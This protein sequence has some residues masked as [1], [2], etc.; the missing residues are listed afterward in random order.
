MEAIFSEIKWEIER[1]V[2]VALRDR[3]KQGSFDFEALETMVKDVM[4]RCGTVAVERLLEHEDGSSLTRQ[5][6]CGGVF[7]VEKRNQCKRICTVVGSARLARTME[8]C[9]RCKKRRV[10]E[11]VVLDVERTGYSP[12]MRRMMAKTGADLCFDKAQRQIIGLAGVHVTDKD[13]ERFAEAVGE[14]VARWEQRRVEAAL[15]EEVTDTSQAPPVLYITTD[16]TGVPVLRRET[17]GRR[18]KSEDRIAR[19]RDVKLGAVFT[20]TTVDDDGDPIRDPHSTTYVGKIETSE[21]FGPRLYAEAKRRGLE[22]AGRVA[23]LGDGAPW[24]WNLAD[25]QFPKAIQ[26][27][28]YYHATE[29]LGNVAHLLYPEDEEQRKIWLKP[30]KNMLWEGQIE[31]LIQFL[32]SI[33]AK[34]AKRTAI[35]KE[36]DYFDNNKQRMHYNEY[37]KDGLFIGSGVIEAG[38]K[39]L[40]GGRLKQSGMHWSVR[41]ANAIIAL[42]CCIESSLFE[43]YW[44]SRRAA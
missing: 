28:D 4:L 17:E 6:E 24:V 39:S 22:T 44:E 7:V 37:R 40:I 33:R 19:N 41:G 25:M 35:Q 5:C 29:H 11:D 18:G 12:G 31:A 43:D 14:D 1:L 9:N 8:R 26:I 42:R 34:G 20:Q 27:L 15:T 2:E 36:I 30:I 16:A 23:V 13:V 32:H 38:C 10:P 21:S 3:E